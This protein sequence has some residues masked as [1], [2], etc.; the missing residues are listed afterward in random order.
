MIIYTYYNINMIIDIHS[1]HADVLTTISNYK[2][3]T[4]SCTYL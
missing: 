2:A 3:Y 4:Q 1:R